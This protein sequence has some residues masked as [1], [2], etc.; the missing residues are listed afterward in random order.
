MPVGDETEADY[1][2]SLATEFADKVSV[3]GMLC[4]G[5]CRVT[6]QI[7]ARRYRR[8]TAFMLAPKSQ[9]VSEEV[10]IANPPGN[11][12]SCSIRDVNG[13]PE[14]HDE[15]VNPG[16]DDARFSVLR[17]WE[18]KSGVYSNRPR[19]FS[20]ETS[21]FY[22]M[23]HRRVMN[24]A[25]GTAQDYFTD[26]LSKETLV[27]GTTGFILESEAKEME[28]VCT[29]R[30]AQ[31]LLKKPKASKV[32]VS[33]ARNEN[34]LPRNSTMSGEIRVVS[35]AYPEN[36]LLRIGFENPVSNVVPV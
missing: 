18:G 21:D 35:L 12:L 16:L 8:P 24:L 29:S 2:S 28:D 33:I 34:L 6:S 14:E 36:I 9:S 17:T 7:N 15:T 5:A 25:R 4:G 23:P 27:D 20:G 32:S 3:Y 13:N 1:L 19:L 11:A 22:L 10:D 30:L 31:V 26:R